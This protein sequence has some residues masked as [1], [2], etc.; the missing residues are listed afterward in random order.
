MMPFQ[1]ID[2]KN[3]TQQIGGNQQSVTANSDVDY[4][5]D[6]PAFY[7]EAGY[8]VTDTAKINPRT[9]CQLG[10]QRLSVGAAM[11]MGLLTQNGPGSYEISEKGY[12]MMGKFAEVAGKSQAPKQTIQVDFNATS[13]HKELIN[14]IDY[15]LG[16]KLSMVLTG[17]VSRHAAG[18]D[19]MDP[20]TLELLRTKLP[21]TDPAKIEAA[22]SSHIQNGVE[23]ASKWVG[24]QTGFTQGQVLATL[25]GKSANA[26]ATYLRA[27]VSGQPR[28]VLAVWQ[29]VK[30]GSLK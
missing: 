3:C 7:S 10:K 29:A 24:G 1:T 4:A 13:A 25:Q 15:Q 18:Q 2:L 27:C 28:E 9:V 12:E 17:V 6:A 14:A 23:A 22:L 21:G 26:R 8:P 19:G 16:G 5:L 11:T 30:N 20:G